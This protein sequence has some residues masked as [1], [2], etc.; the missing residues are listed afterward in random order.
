MVGGRHASV[1]DRLQP[2]NAKPISKKSQKS[3][4][5]VN[6]KLPACKKFINAYTI[7]WPVQIC[8]FACPIGRLALLLGLALHCPKLPHFLLRTAKS[9]HNVTL[10]KKEKITVKTNINN[11]IL[12]DLALCQWLWFPL[13][14][15]D[16]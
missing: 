3:G 4:T 15:L 2:Y 10:T 13:A 8:G 11:L 16:N 14:P 1:S 12:G 6:E 5:F 7:F 9:P